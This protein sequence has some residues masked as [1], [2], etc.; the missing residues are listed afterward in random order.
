MIHLSHVKIICLHMHASLM[1]FGTRSAEVVLGS[2]ARANLHGLQPRQLADSVRFR[3]CWAH[4]AIL[5]QAGD[6]GLLSQ[7]PCLALMT[8]RHLCCVGGSCCCR[9]CRNGH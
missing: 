8:L 2:V 4:S 6:T 9:G 3:L 7:L 5:L 1:P